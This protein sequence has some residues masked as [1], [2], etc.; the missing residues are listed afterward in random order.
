M[1][2][3][4]QSEARSVRISLASSDIARERV[5]ALLELFPE[6]GSDGKID[7]DTLKATLGERTEEARER[8]GLSWAGKAEAMRTIQTSSIGTLLPMPSESVDFE[9]S[10]NV[11]IEGDNLE[12]LK[13]LQKSYYNRVGLIYIDPP[14]NTGNEF[15]YPDN[16]REGLQD[17]LRY[18]G[19]V[20]SEGLKVSTNTETSGRF[21]AKWLSMMWPRLFL[22][23]NLL[24]DDGIIFVS[25]D[26]NEVHNLRHLM[27]EIF[28]SEN[29]V[30]TLVWE[31]GR[32]NDARRFSVG[33]DY[34]VGYARNLAFVEHV[35]APWREP[36]VGVAEIVEEY[37]RLKQLHGTDYPAVSKGL[38]AFYK[39]LPDDHPSKKYSRSRFVDARGIWRDNNISWPGGGG[40]RYDLPHPV[41][42]QPCKVPDDGWRF[43][44]E[45]MKKKVR[46][47]WVEFREDHT[48]SPFL[49][50]YLYIEGGAVTDDD[51]DTP[52]EKL[53]VMGSVFYRHSQPSND[54][55]K[56]L[57]GEKIFENP[58]DHVVLARLFR[59]CTDADSIVLDFFAGSGSAGHAVIDLNLRDGSQRQY[60]LVQLPEPTE[61]ED[62]PT[63]ASITRGRM[64]AVADRARKAAAAELPGLTAN[65][66]PDIGFRAFKLSSS[67]FRIW[68][69][70]SASDSPEKLVEQIK[71]FA[72][73]I[74]EGRSQED[75]LY[76]II[77]KAGL[78]LAS[79]V[80][81][82][83]VA[84]AKVYL[85]ADGLL[86]VC[87]A[88]PLTQ[89][90]LREMIKLS[91]QRVLCL[92]HAFRGNDK[93]KVNT[94]LE[95]RSHGIEFRTI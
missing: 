50:S 86:L 74:V 2:T 77:L 29:Y 63:I 4:E 71:L 59:Y 20:D 43:V 67:N 37:H 48:K 36:K 25:I 92:D 13:L 22:A 85:V 53:Q 75:L 89:A 26:D 84:G 79:K 47:G 5:D 9:N 10:K 82:L 72:D 40:P 8:Y 54:V 81:W 46:D 55:L 49:K 44:E 58:K 62:Y 91:P 78:P 95:M 93:E 14:Y 15:I 65:P 87:L 73:N 80:T 6:L 51:D 38:E 30:A 35:A 45:T 94:L 42:K 7:L 1:L 41:T 56:E 61:R 31:K 24:R 39:T 76:E 57:F 16:F 70:G 88:D 68:D 66:K 18:S 52:G 69:G 34:I 33:H 83:D 12:V 60:I 19:Q 23:R 27:D 32:K 64:R 90:T 11:V 28:G 3:K 21:H 17:Y